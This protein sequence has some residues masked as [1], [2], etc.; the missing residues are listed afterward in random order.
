MSVD[1]VCDDWVVLIIRVQG[2]RSAHEPSLQE[3]R[4]LNHKKISQEFERHYLT[5]L[6]SG[7]SAAMLRAKVLEGAENGG[8]EIVIPYVKLAVFNSSLPDHLRGLWIKCKTGDEHGHTHIHRD[9]VSFVPPL[10]RENASNE[11]P[12]NA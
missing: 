7:F 4:D 6:K 3:V 9:F 2:T 8:P 12:S 5:A 10:T 11:G 1:G